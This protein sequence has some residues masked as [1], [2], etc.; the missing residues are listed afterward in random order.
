MFIIFSVLIE[1]R[2]IF[3]AVYISLLCVKYYIQEITFK[4]EK[5]YVFFEDPSYKL[6][7][8]K[9]KIIFLT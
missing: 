1:G 3:S 6:H 2:Q 7:C 5:V 9:K 4:R 8:V